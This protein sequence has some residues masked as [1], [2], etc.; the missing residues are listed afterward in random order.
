MT[1]EISSKKKT[2][3]IFPMTIHNKLILALLTL[4]L[5]LLIITNIIVYS[6]VKKLLSHNILNHLESVASIQQHR[7]ED[8]VKQNSERLRLVASRTQMHLSLDQF[9]RSAD[10]QHQFKMNKILRDAQASITDF[11]YI[12][13]HSPDGVLVASSGPYRIE[14]ENCNEDFFVS[15]REG[16]RV[17][18]FYLDADQNISLK[19]AG[20]L[21]LENK[22]LGVIF[23]DAKVDNMITAIS[24]YTGLGETGETILAAKNKNGDTVF[25]MPT[26]FDRQA[27]LRLTITKDDIHIPI[28][29]AFSGKGMLLTDKTDYRQIPVLAATRYIED[30]NWGIV[31]KIDK[32]EAF[33]PLAKMNALSFCILTGG[34]SLILFLSFCFAKSITRP[35]LRLTGVANNIADDNFGEQ[36][37]ESDKDEIGLLAAAFNKMTR[38]LIKTRNALEK[39]IDDLRA[40]NQQLQAGEERYRE[41][42]NAPRDAI[43]I[44]D[45]DT[46]KILDV[47]QGMLEMYGY[48]YPDS[49][50]QYQCRRT[51][52]YHGRGREKSQKHRIAKPSD[53]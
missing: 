16:N 29:Q 32:E 42:Y 8:I 37:E 26:R 17:D 15:A 49:Y 50:W 36:A 48:S 30:M 1:K 3:S 9:L 27:A 53:F 40:A 20:P 52:L 24:D 19:T 23:I 45:A 25:V 21:Y 10:K 22:F 2:S 28:N 47:N 12:C 4:S 13:V 44:H 6:S 5:P 33:A 35:I 38:K 7:I 14:G 39:N 18:L 11:K 31:V 43:F 46:G 41:I 34:V 51:P